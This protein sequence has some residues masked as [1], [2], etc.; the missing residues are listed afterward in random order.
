M[1]VI[2]LPDISEED[3]LLARARK[4]EREA[5]MHIYEAYFSPV[6]Q[7]IRLRTPDQAAAEDIT[8]EVFVRLVEALPGKNAPRHSLRG[9]LFRVARS[10]LHRHYGRGSR[11]RT[12]VLEEWVPAPSDDEPEMR[13]IAALDVERARQAI[14]ML[15]D[16]QQE[17]LILRFGQALSLQETADIMDKSVSAVKSLQFRAVDT[18]RRIL[19]ELRT[20]GGHG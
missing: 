16:D 5:I 17:V 13:F 9:W 14:R 6:Y 2:V 11:L 18:L 4:G 19:G 8:S 10:E 3:D 1:I 12:T 7:F 15:N 20:E